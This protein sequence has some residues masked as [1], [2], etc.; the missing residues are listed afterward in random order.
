MSHTNSSFSY[1][2]IHPAIKKILEKRSKIDN[3]VQVAMP[4]VKAT[5]TI[6]LPEVLGNGIGFTLGTHVIDSDIRAQDIFSSIQG[7]GL[8]GYTYDGT[9]GTNRPIYA[10]NS[11]LAAETVKFFDGDKALYSS[12]NARTGFIPPPGITN[13]KINTN[14][15]GY[16]SIAEIAFSVPTLTQ[17]EILHRVFLVPAIGMILEWG[18]QFASEPSSIKNSLKEE[19]LTKNTIPS[20]LFPWYD[21]AARDS[22]F[23]K[24]AAEQI[25]TQY[26]FNEYSYKTEG[27]YGWMFGRVANFSTRGNA[28]GSYDCT[29]KIVGQGENS[30]AYST[31][32]TVVPPKDACPESSNSVES[33]LRETTNGL[34][35]KS[36]LDATMSGNVA[37]LSAWKDHVLMFEK[38]NKIEGETTPDETTAPNTSQATF[39][40][41]EDAYFMTWKFF[42]NVVLNNENFGIKAIFKKAGLSPEELQNIALL[43]PYTETDCDANSVAAKNYINDP[44]ENYVGA[45]RFLRS[46][47]PSALIIVNEAAAQ[48]AAEDLSKNRPNIKDEL[49]KP[50]KDV[51]NFIKLG[52]FY[53]N[54]VAKE[55]LSDG[56][57]QDKAFLSAGVWLNHKA[58][59]QSMI[60]ADTILNGVSALLTR[61]NGATSGFWQLTI[62]QSQPIPDEAVDPCKKPTSYAVVDLNYKENAIYAVNKFLNDPEGRVHTFNKYIRNTDGTL[63]G[64]ELTDCVINLDLPKRLFT[65]IATMGLVQPEDANAAAPDADNVNDETPIIGDP[66]EAMR[67]MFA[68]TSVSQKD[69]S[70]RSPDLTAKPPTQ[71][72]KS[73]LQTVCSKVG[74]QTT[75]GTSGEGNRSAFPTPQDV[76]K[77]NDELEKQKEDAQSVLL[78]DLCKTAQCEQA[79]TLPPSP[80]VIIEPGAPLPP[81]GAAP[82]IPDDTPETPYRIRK[83]AITPA[84]IRSEWAGRRL[85]PRTTR[86]TFEQV[87]K[88]LRSLGTSEPLTISI[89]ATMYSEQPDGSVG[90]RATNFNFGGVDVTNGAWK[91]DPNLHDGYTVL[92]EGGTDEYH[93]FASFRSLRAALAFKKSKLDAKGFGAVTNSADFAKLYY[94]KWNGLGFRTQRVYDSVVAAGGKYNDPVGT[95]IWKEAD[96][97]ALALATK[98]YNFIAKKVAAF[99]NLPAEEVQT[100]PRPSPSRPA[101]SPATPPVDCGPCVRAQAVVNQTNAAIQSNSKYDEGKDRVMREFPY[102]NQ[103]FRY[104]EPYPENMVTKITRDADGDSSNAFGASPGSLSISVDMTMP[105]INGIRVGELFWIDRMPAFYRAFGAF[106]VLNIQQSISMDGWQT[107]I[108]GRFLYLGNAWRKIMYGKLQ[109]NLSTQFGSSLEPITED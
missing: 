78:S 13:V 55:G 90:Y 46:Y 56:I 1:K 102:L 71:N 23:E 58:V 6:R 99:K 97:A 43:R 64:S 14:R 17:L 62:D 42:V 83:G 92:K 75:A 63:Y 28:D 54:S 106:Q 67:K 32:N 24:I 45:N 95:P 96:T 51:E 9:N 68:I 84:P 38:G 44:Y 86:V 60:T 100:P 89:M 109:E 4:F 27:Q 80:A 82:Y 52:D 72:R 81:A 73:L 91:L 79:L 5:T 103:V 57:K 20:K 12:P 22:I 87:Y 31:R 21:S 88:E 47:D 98:Q 10:V 93:A 34:N 39:G 16:T 18:Q 50:I 26:I 85:P 8:I 15:N 25:D 77:E 35:L 36:L 107:M 70:G 11:S 49:I 108:H 2:T 29:V 30:W 7:D 74:G 41:S 53:D 69:A 104:V 33:F 19:G 76:Q 101:P 65:Q 61:M 66:A 59:V 40:D 105:G 3:T 37:E 94:T 48:A